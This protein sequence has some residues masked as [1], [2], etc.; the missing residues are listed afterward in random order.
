ML[1][2]WP[3]CKAIISWEA[4]RFLIPLLD[5]LILAPAVTM[6]AAAPAVERPPPNISNTFCTSVEAEFDT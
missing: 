4:V 1:P 3:A 5:Y 6:L 2:V